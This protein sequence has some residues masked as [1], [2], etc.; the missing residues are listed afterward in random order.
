MLLRHLL[1]FPVL[2]LFS[3]AQADEAALQTKLQE[4]MPDLV[5]DEIQ[6]L[7]NTGLYETV[8]NG[9]VIY[10]SADGRYVFQGEVVELATRENVTEQRRV[11]LRQSILKDLNEKDMIIYGPDKADYTLTVFTDIDCGYCRKMH[12]QMD[13]YNALGI[14]IRYMAY[15]R[16]GIDS[17]SYDK[18][19]SVWCADDRAKALTMAKQGESLDAKTCVNPVR[20]EF[21]IGHKLG[22]TGTP[23]MFLESGQSLPGYIAP[24]RL[25]AILDEQ[26]SS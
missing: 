2:A 1:W 14:R 16:G 22:V 17:E 18:A 3:V 25:K 7:D 24:K 5:I 15:P 12:Q 19:V 9:Q 13:E 6:A 23:S 26:A 10:F 21:E 11:S 4:I 8:I 20:A